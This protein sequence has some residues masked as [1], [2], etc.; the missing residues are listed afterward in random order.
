[1][2]TPVE[3]TA[4]YL[5]EFRRW[6][7][8]AIIHVWHDGGQVTVKLDCDAGEL[9]PRAEYRFFGRWV[10]H[11][12][13]GRQFHAASFVKPVPATR[14]GVLSYLKQHAVGLGGIGVKRIEAAWDHYGPEAVAAIR[15]RPAEVC[16]VLN[17][18]FG[19]EVQESAVVEWSSR[20]KAEYAVEACTLDLMGLLGG[21]GFYRS[22]IR[23]IVRR[24]GNRGAE[25]VRRDP[26]K[27]MTWK[28]PGAGF[29]KCDSLYLE[30]GLPPCRLKRQALAAWYAASS[31]SSGNT[32]VPMAVALDGIR[33]T[34]AGAALRPDR[35]IRMA[36]RARYLAERQTA[37]GF[38]P[39]CDGDAGGSGFR[40]VAVGKR[41]ENEAE[42]ARI[43]A[44]ASREAVT[45]QG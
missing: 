3:I 16:G 32:W 41:A 19:R 28:L 23:E 4:T 31:D 45:W 30:L 5:R 25:E 8:T 7:Q 22:I 10:D 18:K 34:V 17:Q 13:F 1:M 14:H 43:V 42:L 12:R 15:E 9:E 35:A 38:G 24:R 36:V 2:A 37:G 26:Y 21:K 27:L 40:W 39:L 11:A 6:E 44:A 29:R 33:R 20:L